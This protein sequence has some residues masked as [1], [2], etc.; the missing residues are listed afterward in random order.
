MMVFFCTFVRSFVS[1][2]PICRP[3]GDERRETAETESGFRGVGGCLRSQF[4]ASILQRAVDYVRRVFFS[5]DFFVPLSEKNTV[6]PTPHPFALSLSL[7]RPSAL[8]AY[9]VA[10][11]RVKELAYVV[12]HW[13][14][15]RCVNNASEGTL[16][17]Y[18]Y[19]LCLVHFL[20]TRNP[21]VVPNLQVPGVICGVGVV[22]Y[23]VCLYDGMLQLGI[24]RPEFSVV[25]ASVG[26][27]Q[28]A[29]RLLSSLALSRCF[30][31][32]S[33]QKALGE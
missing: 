16:S 13:A 9:S 21:P 32:N 31:G 30:L 10:D 5:V 15:R 29:Y 14:K 1:L 27:V 28:K 19:L 11:P 17:S 20:Q 18:G 4:P 8:Q 3:A 23:V 26:G 7:F 33:R 25:C 6:R 2:W 24:C 12:K 22:P